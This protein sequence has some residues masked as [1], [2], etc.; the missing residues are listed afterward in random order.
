M[1]PRERII[2]AFRLGLKN[3]QT[4]CDR[5]EALLKLPGLDPRQKQGLKL[6]LDRLKSDVEMYKKLIARNAK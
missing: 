3:S 1:T 6:A 4:H 2:A 5:Y